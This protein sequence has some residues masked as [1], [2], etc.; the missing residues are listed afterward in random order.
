TI[1]D[2]KRVFEFATETG[3]QWAHG[4]SLPQQFSQRGWHYRSINSIHAGI[5][6]CPSVTRVAGQGLIA[7][8]TGEYYGH[9]LARHS[10]HKIQ[11]DAGGPDD[12]LV[13]MPNQFG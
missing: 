13:L 7:A 2:Q 4:N 1:A 10:R 11:G 6:Q 5:L 3:A 8:F 12:R 9:A